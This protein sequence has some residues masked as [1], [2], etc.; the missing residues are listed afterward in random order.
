M[1]SITPYRGHSITFS[2]FFPVRMSLTHGGSA[3]NVH[4]VQNL[5]NHLKLERTITLKK[6]NA[7]STQSED[8]FETTAQIIV[9]HNRTVQPNRAIRRDLNND[10]FRIGRA[11]GPPASLRQTRR[12]VPSA[13][14]G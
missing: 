6:S 10:C 12:G 13:G 3:R 11:T 7:M 9:L 4:D 1:D 2:G 5:G 14:A 8:L